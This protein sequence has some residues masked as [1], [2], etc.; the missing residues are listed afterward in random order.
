MREHGGNRTIGLVDNEPT[1]YAIAAL[2]A[3]TPPLGPSAWTFDLEIAD[4]NA[5][6]LRLRRHAAL[7]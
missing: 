4:T 2:P 3:N 6:I 1:M 7:D 5:H